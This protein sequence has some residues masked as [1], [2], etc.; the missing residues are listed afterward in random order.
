[1]AMM[2]GSFALQLPTSASIAALL[3]F[4][5]PWR[6]RYCALGGDSFTLGGLEWREVN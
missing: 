6:Y 1:M 5:K 3:A 2:V 4:A